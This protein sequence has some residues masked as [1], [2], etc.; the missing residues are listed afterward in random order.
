MAKQQHKLNLRAGEV[1]EVRSREEILATLDEN[2]RLDNL[3]FMPEMLEY[4]GKKLKVYKRAHK[5]CDNIKAWSLR[6]VKD[7]VHLEGI[8]C[9]GSDHAGCQAGCLIFWKEAWLKRAGETAAAQQPSRG[10]GC[11]VESLM[12]AT[13]RGGTGSDTIYACQG[14]DLREFS[15][16]LS[17]WH[18]GQYFADITSGNLVTGLGAGEAAH[19]LLETVL[20]VMQLLRAMVIM[21]F[22]RV[23]RG[24]HSAQYPHIE[25]ALDKTPRCDLN[26]QPGEFVQIRSKDEIVATLNQTNRNRGLVFEGEMLRY[27]GG[28]HRVLRRVERIIDEKTGKLIDMKNPCIVLDGVFCQGDNHLCCPRGI[29]SYWRENWLV[30]S[31]EAPVA[32]GARP[33]EAATCHRC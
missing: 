8:R 25:G 31:N 10:R 9:D 17:W 1:V 4:C 16:H 23:Q 29:Y 21:M 24:R 26:L 6:R 19:R 7:A 27:C 22:N 14:T 15:S 3:P 20:S 33:E 2:G 5:T 32:E 12:R 30:R 18:I 13:Q 11:S 28:F